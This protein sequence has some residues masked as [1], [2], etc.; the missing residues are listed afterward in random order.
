MQRFCNSSRQWCGLRLW[1]RS[2]YKTGLRPTK[3]GFGLGLGLV[4]YD[5]D[6]AKFQGAFRWQV[7]TIQCQAPT[8]IAVCLTQPQQCWREQNIMFNR[9][10]GCYGFPWFWFLYWLC[11]Q[12]LSIA[13]WQYYLTTGWFC[14]FAEGKN[15]W[16]QSSSLHIFWSIPL[17]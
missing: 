15:K 3:F 16:N 11:V 13:V 4:S 2:Y 9:P 17:L 12:W 5:L 8:N 1:W 7:R 6:V 14:I 10:T